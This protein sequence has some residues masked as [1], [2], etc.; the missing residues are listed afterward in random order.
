MAVG[1]IVFFNAMVG[2]I[3]REYIYKCKKYKHPS[4]YPTFR[5]VLQYI[6]TILCICSSLFKEIINLQYVCCLLVCPPLM[7]QIKF[8]IHKKLYEVNCIIVSL[9]FVCLDAVKS[10]RRN[11]DF[12]G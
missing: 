9:Y 12:Y 1:I 8:F 6:T 3:F 10:V 2:F 4:G 7:H 5:R 11:G